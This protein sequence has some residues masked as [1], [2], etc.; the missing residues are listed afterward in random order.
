MVNMCPNVPDEGRYSIAEAATI[1]GVNRST[2]LRHSELGL[3]KFGL[4]RSNARK[5]YVG[6]E[7]NRYWKAMY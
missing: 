2:L 6:R 3:I 1:L 4:R 5:F 7:I